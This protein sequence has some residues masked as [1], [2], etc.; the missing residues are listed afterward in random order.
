MWVGPVISEAIL[1]LYFNRT[2]AAVVGLSASKHRRTISATSH[3]L[4]DRAEPGFSKYQ[5]TALDTTQI[6][7]RTYV[8]G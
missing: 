3:T 7:M 2:S 8:G 6:N 4:N 5:S 1:V